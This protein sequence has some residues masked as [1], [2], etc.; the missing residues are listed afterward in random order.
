M[1]RNDAS[2]CRLAADVIPTPSAQPHEAAENLLQLPVD[3]HVNLERGGHART[4][5]AMAIRKSYA[6][7]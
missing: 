4:G 6:W 2:A 5:S 1:H 7:R 3:E